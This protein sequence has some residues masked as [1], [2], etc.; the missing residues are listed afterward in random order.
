MRNRITNIELPRAFFRNCFII[1]NS[2]LEC[3]C[4]QTSSIQKSSF[5]CN[6]EWIDNYSFPCT[7][8]PIVLKIETNNNEILFDFRKEGFWIESTPWFM[9]AL[10]SMISIK[11]KEFVMMTIWS[12]SCSIKSGSDMDRMMSHFSILKLDF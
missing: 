11:A 1:R 8:I 9:L 5:Y 3:F 4:R 10:Q 7:F 12:N 2:I 6:R